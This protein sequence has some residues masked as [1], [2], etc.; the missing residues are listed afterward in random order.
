MASVKGNWLVPMS[1][2]SS[3]SVKP[4]TYCLGQPSWVPR[5]WVLPST[6][7]DSFQW[8]WSTHWT[9]LFPTTVQSP[10]SLITHLPWHPSYPSCPPVVLFWLESTWASGRW[11]T[12]PSQCNEWKQWHWTSYGWQWRIDYVSPTT[13]NWYYY[14]CST[15]TLQ[16]HHYCLM[17]PF[18][19]SSPPLTRSRWSSNYYCGWT[20]MALPRSVSN[21]RT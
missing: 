8:Y 6:L 19:S 9:S 5:P 21:Y 4:P 1:R 15:Q 14:C 17:H 10:V 3:Y 12:W 16:G 7:L 18:V 2:E 13:S 11:W 20:R